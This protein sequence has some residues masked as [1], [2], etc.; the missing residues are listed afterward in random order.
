[1]DQ[2]LLRKLQLCE[3]DMLKEV[4][5]ICEKYNITY[6][7]SSGTLLGAV[8]HKGFIPWD[9]D[10]DIEMPY[11][12]YK[13]FLSVAQGELGDR[14]FLQ[15]SETD[16]GHYLAFT[17]IRKNG[18]LL[19]SP[20]EPR[21]LKNHGVWIDI[22]PITTVSGEKN[23]RLK[24]L[25]VTISNY[26]QMP[27]VKF[28][29]SESWIQSQS[30]RAQFLGVKLMRTLPLGMRRAIRNAMLK[31][32]FR[33]HISDTTSS[34]YI[35]GNLSKKRRPEI[36]TG[37]K[38]MLPFEDDVFPVPSLYHEYLTLEYGDYMTPPPEN[39]RNGGHGEVIIKL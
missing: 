9:D 37:E 21:Y 35:W 25:F 38:V 15:T 2:E 32:V 18:T 17:K 8:R 39:E 20:W 26:L 12:D 23:E 33:N 29:E 19:I 5:R 3:L 11:E 13:R 28:E 34:V 27:N 22:F 1:M 10:I 24:R 16:P 7:L 4:K 31:Y 36:Y 6:Y 14:Y 30:S